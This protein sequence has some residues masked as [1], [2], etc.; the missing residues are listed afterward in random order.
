MALKFAIGRFAT[1]GSTGELNWDTS[2]LG[3]ET[4]VGFMVTGSNAE[5]DGVVK[6]GIVLGVGLCDDTNEGCM[7]GG[8]VDGVGSS[9]GNRGTH[10]TQVIDFGTPSSSTDVAVTFVNFHADGIRLDFTNLPA[11]PKLYT[12]FFWA[13]SGVSAYMETVTPGNN[14]TTLN[15]TGASF[16][17]DFAILITASTTGTGSSGSLTNSFGMCI[18][19]SDDACWIA[20]SFGGQIKG[21][22][23][24]TVRSNRCAGSLSTTGGGSIDWSLTSGSNANGMD[25]TVNDGN[26]NRDIH[27]LMFKFADQSV[28]VGSIDS[29][30]STGDDVHTEPGFRPQGVILG[31]TDIQTVDSVINSDT[32]GVGISAF[33]PDAQFCNSWADEDNADPTNTQS[34]SDDQAV[35]LFDDSGT[36]IHVG[37][38]SSMNPTGYTNNYP[39]TADSTARKWFYAAFQDGGGNV[40]FRRRREFIGIR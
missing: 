32:F 18:P 31:L 11:T 10:N 40:I 8:S 5:S 17:A 25:L 36:A 24:A 19:G 38:H 15:I 13:G 6:T 23:V 2:D 9:A 16:Q 20:H 7:T 26:C 29:P 1:P 35:N 33:T 28:K 39:S 12:V 4:P 22:C 37:S 21:I 14:G 30:T 3:G 27:V 34:L